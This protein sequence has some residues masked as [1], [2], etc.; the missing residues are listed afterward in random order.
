MTSRAITDFAYGA[1]SGNFT[2]AAVIA[3]K[4]FV[5]LLTHSLPRLVARNRQSP[6]FVFTDASYC[7]EDPS[8]PCGIGGALVSS[9]GVLVSAFSEL[10][11]SRLRALLGEGVKK[12]VIFEAELLAVVCA[13]KLWKVH[14]AGAPVVFYIDNNSARD[15]AIS[16]SGRSANEHHRPLILQIYHRSF[17]ARALLTRPCKLLDSVWGSAP[18][19]PRPWMKKQGSRLPACVVSGGSCHNPAWTLSLLRVVFL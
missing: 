10:V 6:W 1:S 9:K 8:W 12:T 19:P 16:G 2:S 13:I 17:S 14:L 15:V 5:N 3:L 11:G 4:R 7:A 18:V